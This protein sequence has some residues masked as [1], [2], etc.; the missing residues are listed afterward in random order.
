MLAKKITKF[1]CSNCG[2]SHAK[3]V[4]QCENCHEWNTLVQEN[5]ENIP[6]GLGHAKGT[7]IEFLGLKGKMDVAPRIISNVKEFP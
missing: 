1:I 3:W 7:Q 6:K 2:T 4:G 5:I